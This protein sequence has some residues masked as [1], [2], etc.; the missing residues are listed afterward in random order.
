MDKFYLCARCLEAN[1]ARSTEQTTPA[2]PSAEQTRSEIPHYNPEPNYLWYTRP[3][4]CKQCNYVARDLDILRLLNKPFLYIDDVTAATVGHLNAPSNVKLSESA[5]TD[6]SE[7]AYAFHML[8][9]MNNS[10]N[11][12]HSEHIAD[13][14]DQTECVSTRNKIQAEIA[15]LCDEQIRIEES[16]QTIS[17]QILSI[18][19]G[20]R[21]FTK[22]EL[23]YMLKNMKD[24]IVMLDSTY[25]T[26]PFMASG[27]VYLQSELQKQNEQLAQTMNKL[28]ELRN[29]LQQLNYEFKCRIQKKEA[30]RI[31]NQPEQITLY[32]EDLQHSYQMDEIYNDLWEEALC[33]GVYS[34][35]LYR[36]NRVK[37]PAH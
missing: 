22:E 5:V 10:N 19:L 30:R 14:L 12:D 23:E 8:E 3:L 25:Q 4:V 34:H 18:K 2:A 37:Q 29:E 6:H 24:N 16:I 1:I 28:A 32:P 20:A 9:L 36:L 13:N 15:R 35:E 26:P 21:C 27:E 31:L 7:K 17:K 11:L 33:T